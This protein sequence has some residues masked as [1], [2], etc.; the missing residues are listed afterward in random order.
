MTNADIVDVADGSLDIDSALSENVL[1]AWCHR[2][3]IIARKQRLSR[4]VIALLMLVELA[5]KFVI[6][7]GRNVEANG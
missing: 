1:R 2:Q 6:L 7:F 3:P 4:A 5:S